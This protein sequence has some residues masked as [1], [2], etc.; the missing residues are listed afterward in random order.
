MENFLF[1][2]K[3][4]WIF[5]NFVWNFDHKRLLLW[6]FFSNV[7]LCG[8]SIRF[9]TKGSR[10]VIHG[11]VLSSYIIIYSSNSHICHKNFVSPRQK[12]IASSTF[13]PVSS[14]YVVRYYGNH[15]F[16]LT[17]QSRS[18]PTVRRSQSLRDAAS[19][20]DVWR[21]PWPLIPC[22][23]FLCL[24]SCPQLASS[25]AVPR[26]RYIRHGRLKVV[27]VLN[28]S[29]IYFVLERNSKVSIKS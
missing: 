1:E 28:T 21:S 2:T 5:S 8:I 15:Y 26:S 16:R 22:L 17:G 24:C 7:I 18:L 27:F 29:L 6:F 20:Q 11:D 13:A 23:L 4:L 19:N 12:C 3:S 10:G 25:S 14:H 9:Q